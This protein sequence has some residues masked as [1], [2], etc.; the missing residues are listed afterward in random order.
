MNQPRRN[1]GG[2]ALKASKFLTEKIAAIDSKAKS[3]E[4]QRL[5]MGNVAVKTMGDWWVGDQC[6]LLVKASLNN[7]ALTHLDPWSWRLV[8]I[9][10]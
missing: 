7:I 1:S 8:A 10:S 4:K 9:G 3:Q 2:G 5:Y 6:G